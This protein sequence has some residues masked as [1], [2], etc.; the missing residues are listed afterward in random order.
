MDDNTPI[1]IDVVSNDYDVNN[2]V[3][4]VKLSK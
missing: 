3:L 4:D 1:T 2:D